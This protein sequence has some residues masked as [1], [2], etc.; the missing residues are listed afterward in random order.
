MLRIAAALR[1]AALLAVFAPLTLA[2]A[3]L[4]ALPL[5]R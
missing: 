5:S 1:A 4:S 3:T 2:T